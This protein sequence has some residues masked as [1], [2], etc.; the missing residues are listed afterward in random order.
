M[1]HLKTKS[2]FC[3]SGN[4]IWYMKKWTPYSFFFNDGFISEDT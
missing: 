3:G 1:A 2:E 4:L